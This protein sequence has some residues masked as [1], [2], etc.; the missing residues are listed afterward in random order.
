MFTCHTCN[1]IIQHIVT[2]S[3]YGHSALNIRRAYS[4]YILPYTSFCVS[5]RK[6]VVFPAFFPI[7]VEDCAL[8]SMC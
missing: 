6:M 7:N 1:I 4:M 3:K 2:M 5:R 8:S